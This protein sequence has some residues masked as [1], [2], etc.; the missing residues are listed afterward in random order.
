MSTLFTADL[1]FGHRFVAGLRGFDSTDAHDS[2]LM[3]RWR[4]KVHDDNDHV[5]VLGDLAVSSPTR[6]LEIIGELPGV[7]HLIAGNHDACHPMHR[8]AHKWQRKYLAVFASVQPFARRRI[9]GTEV[10]LS[11]FPYSKDHHEARY[12]QY[13]LRDEGKWLIHGHTHEA[14]QRREGREIHVGVD[15]WEF[16]PVHLHT[17]ADLIA[18]AS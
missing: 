14:D 7:K 8:D 15:A 6:A 2:F 12:M 16:E 4:S 11:H 10:M 5:W 13:R 3:E 1:H 17:I 9:N 18:E